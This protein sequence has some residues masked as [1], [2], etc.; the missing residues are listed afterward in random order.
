MS[1]WSRLQRMLAGN[2]WAQLLPRAAGSAKRRFRDSLTAR[3]LHAPGF[4]VGRNPRILGLN[5]MRIGQNFQAGDDLWLEAVL[6]FNG[7]SFEPE[8]FIGEGVNFSDRVHIACVNRV[9]VGAGTLIG[10]RV[11]LTDHTH[12][13]YQGELQSPPDVPPNR[14]PLF[15]AGAVTVGRNVWIGNGVAVLAGASIGD[16]AIVG[17][18]SVVTGAIP[19]ATLAVGA[20]ARPVR[21]WDAARGQWVPY[22]QRGEG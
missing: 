8:I 6:E 9:S 5:R 14:Q 15:S 19:A 11:I 10:S 22:T 21:Q 13:I 1:T 2:G 20:P 16:G 4:R 3:K 7:Q 17:A 18:N 12:G